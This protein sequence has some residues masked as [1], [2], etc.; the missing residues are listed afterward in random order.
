M[1]RIL[2]GRESVCCGADIRVEKVLH[3]VSPI[4]E[5][6]ERFYCTH[7]GQE[8]FPSPSGV[9]GVKKGS[10]EEYLKKFSE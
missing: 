10:W 2:K 3:P 1:D 7:C 9:V 5:G 6:E 4:E 8:K